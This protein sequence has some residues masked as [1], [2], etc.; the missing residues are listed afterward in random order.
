MS[1]NLDQLLRRPDVW[2]PGERPVPS[3]RG[4]PTGFAALDGVLRESGWPRG[5]LIELLSVQRGAGELRLLLPA[6]A[7]LS[8]RGFY[9]LWI[10]PPCQPFA[11]GL[12]WHGVALKQLVI[13]RPRDHRQW[14]WAAE[15]A[16]RSSG[17]GA[18]VC[19]VGASRSRYAE[20]RKLQVAAAE[21]SCIGF[22]FG[23]PRAS[24]AASPAA[25]RLRLTAEA[26]GLCI[27]VLKQRGTQAGQRVV[28]D[29]PIALRK[30]LPLRERPVI[31]SAPRIPQAIGDSRFPETVRGEIWQ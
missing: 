13:V 26:S 23:D 21:R 8:E 1:I 2:K 17:C 15:Q 30:Q 3:K 29:T 10:D 20:L 18:V 31:V 28:L 16:L 25:L 5:A 4:Q 24:E 6:L 7:N 22:V 27:D 19:W 11:P 9:Q 14:L 12:A